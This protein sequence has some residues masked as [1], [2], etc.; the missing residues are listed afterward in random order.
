MTN[1][2]KERMDEKTALWLKD[3]VEQFRNPDGRVRIGGLESAIEASLGVSVG[4][5]ELYAW[6]EE[7]GFVHPDEKPRKPKSKEEVKDMGK[8]GWPKG[9]KRG[10]YKKNGAAQALTFLD[11]KDGIAPITAYAYGGRILI[12]L[13]DAQ[14]IF[15]K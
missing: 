8:V 12:L 15:S 9:K 11:P 7:N 6:L 13:E 1:V 4:N 2:R 14:R 10:K 3:N 5:Y